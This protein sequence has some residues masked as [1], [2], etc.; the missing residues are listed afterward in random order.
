MPSFDSSYT[1]RYGRED[2]VHVT[3]E[4]TLDP[5]GNIPARVVNY[6]I[7]GMPLKT[8]TNMRRLVSREKYHGQEERLR[9]LFRPL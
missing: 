9:R 1:L 7:T 5:G 2:G 4:S 8:L 3:L 6:G